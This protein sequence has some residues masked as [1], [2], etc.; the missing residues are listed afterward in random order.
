MSSTVWYLLPIEKLEHQ[1]KQTYIIN[2][3]KKHQKNEF[4]LVVL[5]TTPKTLGQ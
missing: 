1:Q 4:Q 2:T 5:F 3:T